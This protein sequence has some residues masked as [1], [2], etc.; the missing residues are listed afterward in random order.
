M[1]TRILTLA[2]I[3]AGLLTGWFGAELAHAQ[4]VDRTDTHRVTFLAR[5]V[6]ID[7]ARGDWND[8][9]TDASDLSTAWREVRGGV[10]QAA[11]G[12]ASAID[13]SVTDEQVAVRARDERE[14]ASASA[15]LQSEVDA[16]IQRP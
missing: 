9:K 14:A 15:K 16:V 12:R 1:H 13:R 2:V 4:S 7:A 8:A 5:A 6:T 11:Q 3:A 10:T